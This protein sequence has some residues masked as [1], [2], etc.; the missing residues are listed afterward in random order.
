MKMKKLYI[1]TAVLAGLANQNA[2]AEDAQENDFSLEALLNTGFR[3]SLMKA[4][5]EKRDAVSARD[6]IVAEDI[7]DFPDLNLAES[8]QRMPGVAITREGNEGRQISLRGVGPDFTRVQINGMETMAKS[9]SA[10]DSR[11]GTREDRAFDFNVFASELFSEINITKSFSVEDDEGGVGGT[12]KLTTPKP[13]DN[14]G[15][16]G[17]VNVSAGSNSYVDSVSPRFTGLV[18]NTWD[19][20][21]AL[22]AISYSDREIEEKGFNTFRWRQRSTDN[23]SDSIDAETAQLLRDGELYFARGNRYTVWENSQ[24][25]I[26]V[27]SSFEYRPSIDFKA[28]LS[29]IYGELNNERTEYH[30]STRG[31]SST[32]LGRV[33]AL[34]WEQ[35]GDHKEVVYGEFSD[36]NVGNETRQDVA[37]TT[38]KQLVLD[39]DWQVTEDLLLKALWGY[40]SSAYEQPQRDKVYFNSIENTT[41]T[42]DFTSGDFYGDVRYGIDTT[43]LTLWQVRDID[44]REDYYDDDYKNLKLDAIYD[45]NDEHQVSVG[46]SH[47]AFDHRGV[48]YRSENF[49]SR[50]DP[51]QNVGNYG[52]TDELAFVYGESED[53]RW[54]AANV[55]AAQAFYGIETDIVNP[56]FEGD[57]VREETDAVYALYNYDGELAGFPVRVS[58]GLRHFETETSLF[59]YFGSELVRTSADSSDTLP[60]F[61]A[62]V[63]L[64]DD[65]VWRASYGKNIGRHVLDD[66]R[67]RGGINT[68]ERVIDIRGAVDLEPFE[69]TSYS[70]SF[71]WYF[72]DVGY[73]AVSAFK[74][75]FD[76]LLSRTETQV[77]YGDI[78][79]STDLLP[80]G[81]DESTLY[82]YRHSA[83]SEQASI[84]GLEISAQSELSFLP[85]PFNGL[86]IVGNLTFADGEFTYANVQGTGENI[87]KSFPGLSEV[88]GNLTVY[89]EAE[90]WGGRIAAAYR[91]DYIA[92]VESGLRDEDERGFHATL[93][94]DATA[95]YQIDDNWK[96]SVEVI[97]ITDEREEQYSDS[98]DRPYN[99]TTSGT[100]YYVGVTRKF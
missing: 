17:A 14:E 33:E 56:D 68:N 1:A 4:I 82:T 99:I 45:F 59:G 57:G 53:A 52:L 73:V 3:A 38:Y 6:V 81:Q 13:F 43:D 90:N 61:N 18:S 7:A 32:A 29:G 25:R 41:V 46:I 80:E 71:E 98:N 39:A 72:S 60:S 70:T 95:Y 11:N 27:T 21:G 79:F 19:D 64:N 48:T 28:S 69:T 34:Q 24:E 93:Y 5:E 37:N 58:T 51:N 22:I 84:K 66:L 87:A 76:G 36:V 10:M 23:F 88:S 75:E 2:F 85:A 67:L 40:S 8:I 31:S 44:V 62:A 63:D 65:M 49:I 78:G 83:P 89:Y 86:G 74:Q 16:Q 77:A 100:T 55:S 20:F 47:K 54:L 35:V 92:G 12:V 30:I 94:I 26:G 42:T 50:Q 9:S 96:L 97:N 91:D 15:F